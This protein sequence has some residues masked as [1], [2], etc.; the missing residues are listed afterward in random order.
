[1]H[2][3]AELSS[4]NEGAN[5]APLT[6]NQYDGYVTLR[7]SGVLLQ[8]PWHVLPRKASDVVTRKMLT[9]KDNGLD[10][11]SQ[12]GTEDYVVLN[13]DFSGLNTILPFLRMCREGPSVPCR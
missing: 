8:L 10:Q 13:R 4:G 6:L 7:G 11:V 9:F 12:D 5:P 1:M 3:L 2:T